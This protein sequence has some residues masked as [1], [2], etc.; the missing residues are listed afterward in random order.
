MDCAYWPLHNRKMT[1]SAPRSR[2]W[3]KPSEVR[4][5]APACKSLPDT[6]PSLYCHMVHHVSCT[7]AEAAVIAGKRVEEEE[8][9]EEDDEEEDTDEPADGADGDAGVD[10]DL[11]VCY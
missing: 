8:E 9:E 2:P 11:E 6:I 3:K 4:L 10:D 7:E 1:F 5:Q